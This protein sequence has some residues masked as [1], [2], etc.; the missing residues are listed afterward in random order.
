MRYEPI[1]LTDDEDELTDY[2]A[3]EDEAMNRS[4]DGQFPSKVWSDFSVFFT[5]ISFT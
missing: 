4:M 1:L 2:S 3:S 5:N